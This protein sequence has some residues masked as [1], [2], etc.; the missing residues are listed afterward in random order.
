M[1]LTL[2]IDPQAHC[3]LVRQ[4]AYTLEWRPEA[5]VVAGSQVELRAHCLRAFLSWRYCRMPLESGDITFRWRSAPTIHEIWRNRE[6]TIL[7]ATLPYGARRGERV[8]IGLVCIPPVWAGIDLG[9]SVWTIGP[10]DPWQKDSPLPPARAEASSACVLAVAAGPVERLCLYATPWVEGDGT[11][12]VSVSPQ[13]RFGNSTRFAR[14]V[15]VTLRWGDRETTVEVRE[16][17]E[18]TGPAWATAMRIEGSVPLD[19]LAPDEN[20]ENGR[21]DGAFAVVESNPVWRTGPTG[22]VPTFGEMHCHTEFS[23]DGQ[24]PIEEALRSARDLLALDWAAPGDHNPQGAAWERTVAV[25]DAAD[26][27]GR[28]ATFFGWE[29]NSG[30]GH[31]NYYFTAPDHPLVCGGT[32]GIVNGTPVETRGRLAVQPNALVVPHH[33]NAVSE[34]RRLEDDAPFWHPYEFSAPTPAHRL[35]EIMQC[36][37]NQE[38]NDYTDA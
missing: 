18:Q 6:R 15:P 26:V 25:L 24:R 28:F 27:P 34:S 33:T 16:T 19:R 38:R 14:P 30:Q 37:G 3:T 32:A 20:L 21:F 23:G 9:L 12:R 11:V 7:R 36:R 35:F 13:D 5:D 4:F 1:S 17:C 31:E 29:N 8:E 2:K 10:S 22:L